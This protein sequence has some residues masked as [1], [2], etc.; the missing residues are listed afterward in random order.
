MA[1]DKETREKLIESAKAEF[2]DKGYNKASLRTICANAGVTT[3]AL[4]FFF[5][6]K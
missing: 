5:E 3:G 4:Y 1:H 6:D 2:M